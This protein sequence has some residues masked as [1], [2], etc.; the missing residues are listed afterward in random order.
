MQYNEMSSERERWK[1]LMKQ[2]VTRRAEGRKFNNE[3]FERRE[4]NFPLRK[5]FRFFI[6]LL[7]V[8]VFYAG[9]ELKISSGC[10][11]SLPEFHEKLVISFKYRRR[12]NFFHLLVEILPRCVV[13]RRKRQQCVKENQL[14]LLFKVSSR[15]QHSAEGR[16][17]RFSCQ[18][19]QNIHIM[20]LEI[21]QK[22]LMKF[23]FVCSWK[24]TFCSSFF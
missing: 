13:I 10:S 14:W 22:M 3:W 17:Y 19:Y 4:K 7:L 16:K 23:V 11:L 6:F 20:W 1:E 12:K 2:G 8:V 9:K 18:K 5:E 24:L 21:R 15:P